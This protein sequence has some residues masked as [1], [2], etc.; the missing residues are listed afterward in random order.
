MPYTLD[1]IRHRDQF[2][3][4]GLKP[5][6]NPDSRPQIREEDEQYQ[7]DDDE[8]EIDKDERYMPPKDIEEREP[9]R[10]RL[11]ENLEGEDVEVP[12]YPR[13]RRKKFIDPGQFG[14]RR[15]PK[16]VQQV[17]PDREVDCSLDDKLTLDI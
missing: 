14:V 8:G 4:R 6:H 13:F 5:V 11:Q 7:A 2:R 9:K 3:R 17:T 10:R 1:L 16:V 15:S 12:T